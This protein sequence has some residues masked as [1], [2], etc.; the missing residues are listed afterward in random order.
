MT[1]PPFRIKPFVKNS[2]ALSEQ[3]K[4]TASITGPLLQVGGSI[5]ADHR[6]V[7]S[8]IVF[9]VMER[10]FSPSALAPLG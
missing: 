2:T 9:T 6:L 5:G 1:S 7:G 3:I 8:A 4:N 10:V